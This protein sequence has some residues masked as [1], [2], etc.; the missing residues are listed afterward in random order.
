MPIKVNLRHL[1]EH[2]REL[3]GELPVEELEL[4]ARDE[5]IRP[6]RPLKY[7]LQVEELD[8]SLLVQ[9]EA[10]AQEAMRAD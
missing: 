7:E 3:E 1:E 8:E 2:G 4:D 5:A 6:N 10:L 9:A